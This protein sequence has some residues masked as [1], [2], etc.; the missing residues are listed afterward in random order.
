MFDEMSIM[1]NLCSI[2][3]FSC[4]ECFVDLGN[5]GRTSNI[6]YH[7]LVFMLQDLYNKQKQL[8]AYYFMDGGTKGEM[9]VNFLLEVHDA[10]H[11][12]VL[13]VDCCYV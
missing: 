1:V 12:E 10:S 6:A 8:V 4:R 13:E 2:H 7:A 5:Y 11:N 3:K 9:L